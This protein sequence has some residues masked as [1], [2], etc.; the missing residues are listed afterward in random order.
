MRRVVAI[1]RATYTPYRER[2]RRRGLLGWRFGALV[3]LWHVVSRT[4]H[5]VRR[6]RPR[7]QCEDRQ[8]TLETDRGS[9]RA[10]LRW[11][12]RAESTK[13]R[14]LARCG[15]RHGETK[16]GRR[17]VKDRAATET[18]EL[19]ERLKLGKTRTVAWRDGMGAFGPR[20][21][22]DGEEL[23][24][25]MRPWGSFQARRSSKSGSGGEETWKDEGVA[26][27]QDCERHPAKGSAR[28]WKTTG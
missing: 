11:L 20:M 27:E 18:S 21:V 3:V 13:E 2:I 26:L 23:Q 1:F 17:G 16:H 5:L 9:T 7:K 6:E 24:A 19:W 28:Q 12:Q 15:T 4:A 25:S 22:R 10:S 14:S 8:H